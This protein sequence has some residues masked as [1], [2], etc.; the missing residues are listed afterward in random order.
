MTPGTQADS[1]AKA[2]DPLAGLFRRSMFWSSNRCAPSGWTEHVPF[3]FWLV[4]VLRPRTIVELGVHNGMSYSA[5]CQAVKALGL[6]SRCFGVDTWM[7]DEQAGFYSEDVYRDF[8]AFH[9][10]HYAA[11]S[12]LVRSTFQEALAHF[13]D[14][15]VDL[16]HIDGYHSYE[17]VREDFESWLPKVSA[18]GIV[19]FHDTNV[20]EG[21]FG[22]HRF[23][24]EVRRDRPHFNFLHGHGLGVLGTGRDYPPAL[25]LLFEADRDGSVASD[26]RQIFS[27][28]GQNVRIWEDKKIISEQERRIAETVAER[29]EKVADLGARLAAQQALTAARDA[30]IARLNETVAERDE[31]VADLGARLAAQQAL[32]AA[33]DAD[34]ARLNETVAERDLRIGAIEHTVVALRAST[35]WR[36]TAPLRALRRACGGFGCS[37]LGFPLLQAWRVLR[38]RSVAPLLEWRAVG[39]MARSGLFDRRWYVTAYPDVAAS[40]VDPLRHYIAFGAREGRNPSPFFNSLDYLA[41]NADVARAGLNPLAHFVLY[42]ASEGRPYRDLDGMQRTSSPPQT[43]WAWISRPARKAAQAVALFREARQATGG[44]APL[45]SKSWRTVRREGIRGLMHRVAA[46]REARAERARQ[47]SGSP[48]QP[49]LPV[50]PPKVDIP[51]ALAN[52]RRWC[53]DARPDVSIIIIN[54]NAAP[55]TLECVRQIWANTEGV[56]YQIIIADNGSDLVSTEQLQRLGRGTQFLALGINRFFGEANNIAAEVAEGKYLCFLNNDAF[57]R[58]GWL[59]ALVDELEATPQAG[60]VGPML[61]FPDNSIQEAGCVV[62]EGGY[63]IRFG[64]GLDPATPEFNVSKSVDYVSA[65]ALLMERSVFFQVG[66]FDLA[67][68][69][70]YYEDT[71]LCF[72]VKAVGRINR[73]CAAAKVI[74]IE[75]SSANNDLVMEARRKALGDI[76]RDKFVGRWG[77]YLR[78]RSEDT[79][80]ALGQRIL[81]DERAENPATIKTLARLGGACA[82]GTTAVFTPFA[83][84]PGGGERYILTLASALLARSHRIVLVTPHAYSHLRLKSLQ[85]EFDLELASSCEMMTYEQFTRSCRPDVMVTMGNHIVPDVPAGAKNSWYHCQFPFPLPEGTIQRMSD[86]LAGYRGLIV[87]SQYTKEHVARCLRTNNLPNLPIEVLNPPVQLIGGD[88]AHKKDIILTVGRF[89]SGGH[90]KRHDVLIDAFRT[91]C[92]KLGRKVEFHIAGSSIPDP[93]QMAYL[94]DLQDRAEGLPVVFHVNPTNEALSQL[95]HDACIYWHGTGLGCDLAREPFRA[96]HFGISIVEAMSA[97]CVPLAFD[98]G[99]PREIITHGLDGLLYGSVDSLVEMTI[100]LLQG[101][102][103]TRMRD[104]ARR[105]GATAKR[106]RVERF[107]AEARRIIGIDEAVESGTRLPAE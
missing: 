5:M 53:V 63:P 35:S 62:N 98:A 24:E 107:S 48:A 89:F 27:L 94:R 81:D 59:R 83:L 96:E 11:F 86:N 103:K 85:R 101:A 99:G 30:D 55:L 47:V 36:L 88:A 97:E 4:D 26:V 58:P 60:A 73:Y 42:G 21:R 69:P 84:T 67:Y 56:R 43:L 23:W 51:R 34:I 74:H 2:S 28:L 16:L 70:A 104:M 95:Y 64:R 87:N 106:Y 79:L 80:R 25:R 45:L 76:N 10:Q 14:G 100:E 93:A 20:R 29:D 92:G 72:K 31:K 41:S 68:E 22:V 39:R 32:T 6:S 75:G 40:G 52:S 71:D 54:W 37:R 18:D 82:E 46:L 9:D 8:L 49:L 102:H 57:V 44:F 7:G 105:A 38:T 78:D 15:S 33:R 77:V 65:A 50:E 19:L 66:G 1:S 61:L 17:A 90:S 12:R 13:E 3:A 91:L